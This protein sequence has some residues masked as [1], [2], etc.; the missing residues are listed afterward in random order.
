MTDTINDGGPAYPTRK[1]INMVDKGGQTFHAGVADLPGMSLRDWL[2]GQAIGAASDGFLEV[3]RATPEA[4]SD[5]TAPEAISI[6]AYKI[7]DAMLT[8]RAKQ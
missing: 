8:E 4:I 6:A 1:N 5:L 3:V 7:A 2:A